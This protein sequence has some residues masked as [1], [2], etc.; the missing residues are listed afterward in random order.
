M[1]EVQSLYALR[2]PRDTTADVPLR[3]TLA[4]EAAVEAST[5]C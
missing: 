5:V 4:V 1:R 2:S 3:R